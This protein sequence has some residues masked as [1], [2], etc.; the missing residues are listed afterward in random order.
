MLTARVTA[1]Y[2]A[3]PSCQSGSAG[4]SSPRSE[5]STLYAGRVAGRGISAV[6]HGLTSHRSPDPATIARANS[7]HEH[8]PP[9]GHVHDPERAARG[10]VQQGR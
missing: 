8:N 10:E 9:A 4:A 3:S 7:Y 5:R 6:V 2:S 1:V